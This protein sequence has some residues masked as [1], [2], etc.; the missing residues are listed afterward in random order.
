M[1]QDQPRDQHRPRPWDDNRE[2]DVPDRQVH[3]RRGYPIAL[4]LRGP[5]PRRVARGRPHQSGPSSWLARSPS[6]A[7]RLR[8]PLIFVP[9]RRPP[10]ACSS[11]PT[12]VV[13]RRPR[14]RR[15]GPDAFFARSHLSRARGGR[16]S[17]TWLLPR[18]RR[19]GLATRAVRLL[20]RWAVTDPGTTSLRL[21]T[22][23]AN[24]R[25]QRVAERSGFRRVGIVT[26]QGQIDG[27]LSDHVL[28]SLVPVIHRYA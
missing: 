8:P 5:E 28:Y 14:P 17:P 6:P 19:R 22:E 23:P 3:G 25:S 7:A 24:E 13:H 10:S 27:R 18:A 2:D 4:V 20:S 11:T 21:L 12:L 16:P 26:R 15:V 1:R 9:R